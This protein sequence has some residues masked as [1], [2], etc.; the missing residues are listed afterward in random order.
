[1]GAPFAQGGLKF[2]FPV[3]SPYGA[4]Q[5]ILTWEPIEVYAN[6]SWGEPIKIYTKFKEK[7]IKP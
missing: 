2:L 7:D 1:M 5:W 3:P 4:T 6:S